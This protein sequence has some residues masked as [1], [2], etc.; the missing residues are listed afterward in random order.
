MSNITNII[1][2]NIAALKSDINKACKYAGVAEAHPR[3]IA[4]SKRQDPDR[5]IAALDAGLRIFGENQVQEAASRW[6]ELMKSY[7]GITLHL[8]GGLQSNKVPQAVALFDV[9]ESVDREKIARFIARECKKQGRRPEIFIQVNT[10]EEDQKGG[11]LPDALDSLVKCVRDELSLPLVGLMCI[12]PADDDPAMHFALMKKLAKRHG[13]EHL[14]MGMSSDF[15]LAA[16]M[17]A[18]DIRVGTAIFGE[19]NS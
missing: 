7:Q 6:P 13:L 16:S 2:E 11:V 19:R 18:T 15:A 5:I 4:V 8:I 9:I 1:T 3:L 10:G 14:S 17:G 12:P